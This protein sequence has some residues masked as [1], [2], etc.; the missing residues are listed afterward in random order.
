MFYKEIDP[1]PELA[2]LIKCIWALEHDYSGPFHNYEHLWADANGE[3]IF[4]SGNSYT[5]KTNSGNRVLPQQFVIGPFRKEFDLY[6]DGLT[7]LV[8]V[9]FWPWGLH[10][11][12]HRPMAELVDKILPAEEIFGPEIKTLA[13]RLADKSSAERMSMIRDFFCAQIGNVTGGKTTVH[14]IGSRIISEKGRLTIQDLSRE[15]NV[16]PRRLERVFRIE[17]GLSPKALSRIVR[18]NYAKRLIERN[19]NISLAE[20]TH[21]AGFCDQSHF[22]KTFKEMFGITPGTFKTQMKQTVALFAEIKP[23]V[24]FLQ[25]S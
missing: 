13:A 23:D 2:T 1:G 25:D 21:E 15:F 8:A 19:P 9:R 18:F 24:V 12:S 14:S 5:L 16:S 20:L 22:S 10:Q 7:R 17:T 11:F 4:T 3:L 6:S